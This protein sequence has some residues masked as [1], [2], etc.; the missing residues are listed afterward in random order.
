MSKCKICFTTAKDIRRGFPRKKDAEEFSR[1]RDQGRFA[2]ANW[3]C[4]CNE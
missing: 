3:S 2:V 4:L 1:G